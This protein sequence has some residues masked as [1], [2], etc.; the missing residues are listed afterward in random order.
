MS[1]NKYFRDQVI[2]QDIL[3]TKVSALKEPEEK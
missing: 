3:K 2:R 1:E